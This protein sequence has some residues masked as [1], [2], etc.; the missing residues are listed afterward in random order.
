MEPLK[1]ARRDL[2]LEHP[3]ARPGPSARPMQTEWAESLRDQCAAAGI[4][5]LFKQWGNHR[6][7]SDANGRYM[8]PASKKE[9]GRL[10]D[11]V[12]H[13]AFP[14]INREAI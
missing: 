2:H 9:A 11:G 13:N 3:E 7:T 5:F 8:I 6:P 4:P 1:P 10:L 12:E 14:V